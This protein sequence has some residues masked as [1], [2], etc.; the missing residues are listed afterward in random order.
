MHPYFSRHGIR[1][2][3]ANYRNGR[4]ETDYSKHPTG[5]GEFKRPHK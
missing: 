5:A 1:V 2:Y 3:R 4:V